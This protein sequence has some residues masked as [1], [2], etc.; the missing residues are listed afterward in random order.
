MKGNLQSAA[1]WLIG[2]FIAQ[3]IER[4]RGLKRT[5]QFSS[6]HILSNL[7]GNRSVVAAFYGGAVFTPLASR[8]YKT[9][10]EFFPQ[11]TPKS[12]ARR[13]FF[14]QVAWSPIALCIY[15]TFMSV[16][17]HGLSTQAYY[18]SQ[19]KIRHTLP[20]TLVSNWMFWVPVQA[21]NFLFVHPS[22]WLLT[23][24]LA[25]IPWTAYL[26]VTSNK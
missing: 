7:D 1:I 11:T 6:T 16:V 2:D 23:V 17:A 20:Q 18:D 8:W 14:D 5:G 12:I 4:H 9:L 10:L 22:R 21:A 3:F 25:A 15:F 24:N 19:Y 26:S 13:V